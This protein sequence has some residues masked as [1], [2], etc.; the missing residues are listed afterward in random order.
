MA[1]FGKYTI[2][3]SPIPQRERTQW[4]PEN[5]YHLT[6]DQQI[7]AKALECVCLTAADTAKK[8]ENFRA[9]FWD[10][11]DQFERYIREGK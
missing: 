4:N 7:R 6:A 3:E 10:V 8:D 11:I 2:P 5:P 9:Q 1:D